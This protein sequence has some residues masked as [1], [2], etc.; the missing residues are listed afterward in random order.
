VGDSYLGPGADVSHV[1]I[2]YPHRAPLG[3]VLRSWL[4]VANSD[5]S[6]AL[7]IGVHSTCISGV[8]R[9]PVVP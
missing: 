3:Q 5:W 4:T 8:F 6:N 7:R 1:P 2:T 9:C